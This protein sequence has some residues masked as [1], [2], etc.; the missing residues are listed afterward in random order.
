LQHRRQRGKTYYLCSQV[1]AAEK[2]EEDQKTVAHGQ[3]IERMGLSS[4][5]L[6]LNTNRNHTTLAAV[7]V[8]LK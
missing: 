7:E 1:V 3:A 8:E 5:R 6:N 4:I 2:S